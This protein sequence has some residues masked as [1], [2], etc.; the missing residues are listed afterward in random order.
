MNRNK[1]IGVALIVLVVAAGAFFYLSG[2]QDS[3]ETPEKGNNDSRYIEYA[4]SS[5]TD[6]TNIIFFHASWCPTCR[7]LEGEIKADLNSIPTDM[8]ILKADF[9][10]EIE[11]RQKYEVTYQHTL[12][13]V[14]SEGNQIKKWSGSRDISEIV[15]EV[16][17]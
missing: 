5:L 7:G 14:D 8:T 17:R 6:E 16:A 10:T 2:K 9:D 1:I 3:T 13:Q 11:L 12:V 4:E 15:S